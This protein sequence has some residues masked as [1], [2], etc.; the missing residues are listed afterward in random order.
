LALEEI[1]CDNLVNFFLCVA[2]EAISLDV[3]LDDALV[4]DQTTLERW[5]VALIDL[6]ARDVQLLNRSVVTDVLRK[7]LAKHVTKEVRCQ[8][9][10]LKATFLHSEVNAHLLPSLIID[11]VQLEVEVDQGLVHFESL[12]EI[13][14][15]LIVDH[16][17]AKVQMGQD[18]GLQEVLGN[19]TS[20]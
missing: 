15:S 8:V 1:L 7:T 19:L 5:C 11:T 10:V 20:T 16:V 3:E 6:V 14:T 12:A 9:N 13:P 18:L 17:I 4:C 2:C